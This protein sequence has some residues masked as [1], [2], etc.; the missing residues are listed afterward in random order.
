[1]I[2]SRVE[3]DQFNV[4]IQL[5]M[6][7]HLIIKQDTVNFEHAVNTYIYF[8]QYTTSD[9]LSKLAKIIIFSFDWREPSSYTI[10]KQVKRVLHVIADKLGEI[11]QEAI[12]TGFTVIVQGYGYAYEVT[13][14]SLLDDHLAEF[15]LFRDKKLIK[16]LRDA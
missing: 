1:M 12:A 16:L 5:S 7:W 9:I 4:E 10:I 11:G 14:F 13:D 2:K 8:I 3:K 6:W 15:G